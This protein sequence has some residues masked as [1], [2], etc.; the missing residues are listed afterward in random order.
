[1]TLN[2]LSQDFPASPVDTTYYWMIYR[3]AARLRPL[4]AFDIGTR[5][6]HSAN[7]LAA[8]SKVVHTFDIDDKMGAELAAPNVVF[9]VR[10]LLTDPL[11]ETFVK[12]DLIFLDVD[13]HDGEQ[14]KLFVEMFEEKFARKGFPLYVIFD[15]VR[16]TSGMINFWVWM[17]NRPG[18]KLKDVTLEAGRFGA[19][20]ALGVYN[21]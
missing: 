6:G 12:P 13:P 10:N 20:F 8:G 5:E 11:P 9:H 7:M 19:G 17:Q 3:V 16:L 1:L 14:E 18:W 4:I 2:E 15:D 21:K